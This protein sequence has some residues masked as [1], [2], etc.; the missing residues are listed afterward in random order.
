[1]FKTVL[2]STAGS[3]GLILGQG[4]EILHAGQLG[5]PQ[6]KKKKHKKEKESKG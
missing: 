6:R 2:P 4:T 1:M 5:S 3:V